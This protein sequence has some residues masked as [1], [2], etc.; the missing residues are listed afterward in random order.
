MAN[1]SAIFK[2]DFWGENLTSSSSHKS[3]RPL[4]TLT[5][6]LQKQISI[7]DQPVSTFQFH[8]LNIFVHGTNCIL[9]FQI[10]KVFFR[11]ENSLLASLIFS[12]HPVHTESVAGIVG[13]ADLL[14]SLIALTGILLSLK[15]VDSSL[16]NATAKI[17]LVTLLCFLST[18]C[19]ELGIMLIPM[20]LA[21]E[22]LFKHRV[23]IFPTLKCAKVK[24]LLFKVIAYTSLLSCI[25]YWRLYLVDFTPPTFQEGDNPFAFIN[26]KVLKWINI[27][28][29]YSINCW[30][31][32]AP[33]WLCFDWAFHCI[34]PIRTV[35]EVRVL[36][37]VIFYS[38][39]LLL[40]AVSLKRN[41]SRVILFL[42]LVILSF[43]PASNIVFT[44][45]FVVAERNL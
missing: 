10:L 8:A 45:G 19:K 23:K 39:L 34:Q 13:R 40:F 4:T 31:L 43:L 14:Y 29:L 16:K 24:L 42:C 9:A 41:D 22:V 37:V 36:L 11:P 2:H 38:I 5:F 20:T 32:L 21:L 35:Y 33:D 27:S 6:W 15:S 3:Y 26:P 17:L 1:L 44:V 28:Y 12:L 30:I 18:L 25:I 7:E